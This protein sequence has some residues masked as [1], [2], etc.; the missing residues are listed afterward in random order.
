V[1]AHDPLG[2]DL[3]RVDGPIVVLTHVTGLYPGDTWSGKNVTY[4]RVE[5][6]GGS[7]AVGLQGDAGLFK[8]PQTVTATESGGQVGRATIPVNGETTLTV[9]LRPTANHRCV[10]H[11]TLG[12]TV[13]PKL[14]EKG[15]TDPRPLGAHF[16]RFQYL[17]R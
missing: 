7:L 13:V 15:S 11:F 17:H 14:V 3:Y 16:L 1:I 10:V 6:G 12:R 9:P 5:C 4:Q 2:I 8:R